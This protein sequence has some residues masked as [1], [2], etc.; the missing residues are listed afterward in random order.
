MNQTEDIIK[1]QRNRDTF[2]NKKDW[3]DFKYWQ[4]K[5][6]NLIR[7][8]KKQLFANAISDKKDNKY[9]WDRLNYIKGKPKS[10]SMPSESNVDGQSF[11]DVYNLLNTLNLF[12]LM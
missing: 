10:S 8:S 6:K 2:H 7:A 12:S 3:T 9:L 11:N 1:A 4:N 5:T